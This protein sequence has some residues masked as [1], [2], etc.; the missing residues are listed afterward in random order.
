[1]PATT[2]FLGRETPLESVRRRRFNP[3]TARAAGKPTR[4]EQH[5]QRSDAQHQGKE[6]AEGGVE[7]EEERRPHPVAVRVGPGAGSAGPEP[8]RQEELAEQ[9]STGAAL[10]PLPC[11]EECRRGR[12]ESR[13]SAAIIRPAAE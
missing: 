7:Q 11:G 8:L 2:D 6:E 13:Y 1:M 5:G 4:E 3:S 9:P 12:T 10:R